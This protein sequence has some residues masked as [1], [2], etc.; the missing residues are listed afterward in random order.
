MAEDKRSKKNLLIKFLMVGLTGPIYL[1]L[2]THIFSQSPMALSMILTFCAGGVLYLV[3]E[4]ISPKVA[5]KKHF[6]P[7][8]GAVAGFM[9]GLAGYLI[10][11]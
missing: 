8:L 4:D 3:F 6:L 9:V 11:G 5:M 7:P 10:V 2:G 1:F